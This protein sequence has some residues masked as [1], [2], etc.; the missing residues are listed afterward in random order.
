MSIYVKNEFLGGSWVKGS[1]I[2][3]GVR[4]RL[5]A[6]TKPRESQ[7]QNKDGST[8]MQDVSRVKFEGIDEEFN[9]SLNR[10]TI[11][12]LVDAFGEDSAKWQNKVLTAVTEKAR[13]AGKNVVTVYLIPE[14]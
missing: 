14:N 1:Q 2:Q 9:I 10:A 8:K 13:I 11:N 5:T 6:E 7:W 4:C 12:G 3:S